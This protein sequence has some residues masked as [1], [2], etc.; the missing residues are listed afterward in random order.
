[1]VLIG[2]IF[3][4]SLIWH[5]F[6]PEFGTI[7]NIVLILYVRGSITT[8]LIILYPIAYN[9]YHNAQKGRFCP[10]YHTLCT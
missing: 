1:M 5:S 10:L 3:L 4:N 2:N 8:C 9:V 7:S 6:N